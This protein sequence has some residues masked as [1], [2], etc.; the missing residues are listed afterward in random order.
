MIRA[1]A[2]VTLLLFAGQTGIVDLLKD[3][4][5]KIESASESKCDEEQEIHASANR[6][7]TRNVIKQ[8]LVG[9][10]PSLLSTESPIAYFSSV[11][12]FKTS[13]HIIFRTLLI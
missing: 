5:Q 12:I 7:Q 8:Q 2:L 9:R 3:T 11:L 10:V 1:A 6:Q 4:I 13:R